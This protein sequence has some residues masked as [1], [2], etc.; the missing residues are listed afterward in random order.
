[1]DVSSGSQS[2]VSLL[3]EFVI[4]PNEFPHPLLVFSKSCCPNW[5]SWLDRCICKFTE[6][7]CLDIF[8]VQFGATL[9][10]SQLVDCWEALNQS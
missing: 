5:F 7:Y 2:T 9:E 8:F 1:M 3:N 10:N 4:V 6:K